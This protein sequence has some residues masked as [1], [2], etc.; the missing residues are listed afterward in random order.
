MHPISPTRRVKQAIRMN[1]QRA[2][3]LL[4]KTDEIVD[5]WVEEAN[6]TVGKSSQTAITYEAVYSRLPQIIDAIAIRL[7]SSEAI[8]PVSIQV[9]LGFDISELLRG[10]RT[11][12]S[13][14][15][16]RLELNFSRVEAAEALRKVEEVLDSITASAVVQYVE[17]QLEQ[18]EPMHRAL[19][20]SNQELIRVVQRQKDNASHLAHELKNPLNAIISFSSILLR[21]WEK[22]GS[23]AK[24]EETQYVTRIIENGRRILALIN[25]MLDTSRR[26]SQ[27]PS[28]KVEQVEVSKLLLR[29]TESLEVNALEKGLTLTLECSLAPPIVYTDSL[30]LQQILV[31]LISNAIRYTDQGAITVRCHSIDEKRWALEVSDTGRGI[32]ADEQQDIFKPYIRAG[33][34]DSHAA[35]SSGLGLTIVTKLVE[36]MQGQIKLDSQLGSGST[37][38][39]ILP[40]DVSR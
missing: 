14:I 24:A 22:E 18:S 17:Y 12:R 36:L 33:S 23:S 31:N 29:V 21:K 13:L 25:N 5:A 6:A 26:A 2:E 11:L 10:F 32:S 27:R 3:I 20:S 35:S 37:F 38:S 34:E 30:R 4:S 39:V 9:K 1:N 16:S 40:L 15:L 8:D 19:L 7:S 28:L